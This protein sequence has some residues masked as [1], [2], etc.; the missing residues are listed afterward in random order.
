MSNIIITKRTYDKFLSLRPVF[1]H[2]LDAFLVENSI[3]IVYS[4]TNT[5][6]YNELASLFVKFVF[7]K[8]QLTNLVD[9]ESICLAVKTYGNKQAIQRH[10]INFDYANH[11][12]EWRGEVYHLEPNVLVHFKASERSTATEAG[13]YDPSAVMLII[14]KQIMK[15]E[16]AHVV[17]DILAR[18]QGS[19]IVAENDYSVG[20]IQKSNGNYHDRIR[21]MLDNKV[22]AIGIAIDTKV[23]SSF[24]REYNH[25][26]GLKV[27]KTEICP[28]DIKVVQ[29]KFGAAISDKNNKKCF[30]VGDG[31]N[32]AFV[33]RVGNQYLTL[34]PTDNVAKLANRIGSHK[35]I[36]AKLENVEASKLVSELCN[37]EYACTYGMPLTTIIHDGGWNNGSGAA[38]CT[39]PIHYIID[40][41][42]RGTFAIDQLDQSYLNGLSR[43]REQQLE[44]IGTAV[45]T[46]LKSLKGTDLE[47]GEAIKWKGVEIVRNRNNF[48]VTIDSVRLKKGYFLNTECRSIKVEVKTFSH[49]YDY[50]A[51]LRGNL[52]K[53]Q[54]I[55][56]PETKVTCN[57]QSVDFDIMLNGEN[58]KGVIPNL[59]IYANAFDSDLVFGTD[60]KLYRD[61]VEVT[62]EEIKS[63]IEANTKQIV[64]EQVISAEYFDQ[65]QEE[66]EQRGDQ[67][68]LNSD[69]TYTL[70]STVNA[71]IGKAHYAMVLFAV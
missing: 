45:I 1:K 33:S 7:E 68:S 52:K 69:G 54:T 27:V 25:V 19:L 4:I 15:V 20:G 58:I 67:Y 31:V 11:T 59:E 29:S 56:Q 5:I 63:W 42:L 35:F 17:D 21:V 24:C 23:D 39:K 2:L 14:K 40:K 60:G 18:L 53:L 43:N 22:V 48:P 44:E 13:V 8:I 50:N 38:V 16:R 65:Y 12:I 64:I 28:E 36:P 55:H 3:E 71:I 49:R 47:L 9:E 46:Y 6:T 30:Y 66:F 10:Y 26:L 61:N 51:K 34:N 41:T 32:A 70:K 37:G 62:E 57:G